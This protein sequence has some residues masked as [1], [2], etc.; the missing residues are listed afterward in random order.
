MDRIVRVPMLIS[1]PL[2]VQEAILAL[3]PLPTPKPEFDI[4]KI[5]SILLTST[6]YPNYGGAAT[7]SYKL[8]KYIQIVMQIPCAILFFTNVKFPELSENGVFKI[9]NPRRPNMDVVK[10]IEKSLNGPP[11]FILAK[12]Y[13]APVVSRAIWKGS[14]ITYMVTGT[15]IINE[16]IILDIENPIGNVHIKYCIEPY[17]A[18]D[19]VLFNSLLTKTIHRNLGANLIDFDKKTYPKIIDTSSSILNLRISHSHMDQSKNLFPSSGMNLTNN[20]EY[21]IIL[22]CSDFD[23]LVKNNK[24]V[25]GLLRSPQFNRYKKLILGDNSHKYAN[26]DNSV[27]YGL[28]TVAEC[29]NYFKH[30]KLLIYPSLLDSNPNT[31]REAV[32]SGCLVLTTN[33]VG[34][35]ERIPP[36]FIMNSFDPQLWTDR[37]LDILTNYVD[38]YNDFNF[39][40][41][42]DLAF[43]KDFYDFL[44]HIYAS[45]GES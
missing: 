40:L 26:I 1:K 21:D 19:I 35:C 29:L 18:S 14:H 33:R 5:K 45:R 41:Y 39:D 2:P 8:F 15:P 25:L 11:T 44:N 13:E 30:S 37:I 6:Q 36:R 28:R 23:R 32:M 20:R 34:F 27:C 43:V 38:I 4:R 7:N 10:K 24:F 12:N 16:N 42:D 9:D 22:C 3:E 17:K 31:I